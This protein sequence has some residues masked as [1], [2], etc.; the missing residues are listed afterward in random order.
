MIGGGAQLYRLFL[1]MATRLYLSYVS[2]EFEGDTFFPDFVPAEWQTISREFF[3]A[4]AENQFDLTFL[5]L[6]RATTR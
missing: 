4:D 5:T 6:E 3:P 2:A 1:P